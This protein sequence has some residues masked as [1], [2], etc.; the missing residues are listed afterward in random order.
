MN[1][2]K[3]IDQS[4]GQRTIAKTLSG[5]RFPLFEQTRRF[6]I[7]PSVAWV[8]ILLLEAAVLW[9]IW[10]WRDMPFGDTAGYFAGASRWKAAGEFEEVRM[11]VYAPLYLVFLGWVQRAFSDAYA[12]LIVHKILLLAAAAAVVLGLLRTLLPKPWAWLI[13][14]WWVLVPGNPFMLHHYD[15][16]LFGFVIVALGCWLAGVKRGAIWRGAGLAGLLTGALFVRNEFLPAAGL[17]GVCCIA[18]EIHQVL[19]RR[20]RWREAV[21]NGFLLALPSL[22][23]VAACAALFYN[24]L[25]KARWSE[26]AAEFKTRHD[27]NMA[28]VY[29]YGYKQRHP[30]WTKDPWR[31]G[32]E[33]MER[34]FGKVLCSFSE[35]MRT[36]PRAVLEHVAWNFSLV[37]VGLQLGLFGRHMG[38]VSP[39]FV[40][41]AAS[42]SSAIWASIA[43]ALVWSAGAVRVWG[44]RR[45]FLRGSPAMW[46]WLALICCLPTMLVAIATQRPRPSYI[47]VLLVALMA[48]TGIALRLLRP[49]L[50]LLWRWHDL[51]PVATALGLL[52]LA[53]HYFSVRRPSLPVRRNLLAIYRDLQPYQALFDNRDIRIFYTNV[54]TGQE[55]AYYLGMRGLSDSRGAVNAKL[56]AGLSFE[57]A[58]KSEGIELLYLAGNFSE[59][60]DTVAWENTAPLYGW[61][62]VASSDFPDEKWRLISRTHPWP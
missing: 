10:E 8:A 41:G 34:D 49:R 53:F 57:D 59:L 46:T 54:S 51:L 28:Q 4:S 19:Q 31:D 25:A 45:M 38:E 55:F 36:N 27:V 20:R 35:A 5:S 11:L 3:V 61:R 14:A 56:A 39:D 13:A 6:W 42:R 7:K 16:H 33:L 24:D 50:R 23:A 29:A 18:H 44:R 37:P 1:L 15:V 62:L 12:A 9:R 47:L 2:P 58:L 60:P 21:S 26:I 32:Y 40:D 30:E 52:A 48:F 22:V 43:L 17:F